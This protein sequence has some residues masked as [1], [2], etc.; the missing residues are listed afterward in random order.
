MQDNNKN[1]KIKSFENGREP[2]FLKEPEKDIRILEEK[3]LNTKR[4]HF[5]LIVVI[6]IAGFIGG[7]IGGG[8]LAPRLSNISF[9]AKLGFIQIKNGKTIVNEQKSVIITE[10]SAIIEAVRKVKPAV[11]SI[12]TTKS[13]RDIFGQRYESKG[14][15]GTGFLITNDGLILTNRHVVNDENAQ[16]DVITYDNNSHKAEIVALDPS[17][18]IAFLRIKGDNFPIVTLGSSSNLEVGQR[19]VAIGNALG[20]YQNTVTTGVVSG[21]GRALT[22]PGSFFEPSERLENVIQTDASINPGNSGGPLVNMAGEVIGIN[23]A[24]DMRGQLVSFSIPI[25]PVKNIIESVMK[26]GKILRPYIGIRYIIIT[27]DIA[28]LNNLSVSYGALIFRGQN[29][30]EL[31]VAP[32]S[33][34]AKAGL[35]END[36]VLEINSQKITEENSLA[37]IILNYKVGDEI[38]LKV[39]R[40]NQEMEIKLVLEETPKR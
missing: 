27:E 2:V 35:K 34:G 37:S 20:E 33:P 40:N 6:L 32:G 11:V 13:F 8:I 36:I 38:T 26:E 15:I 3:P 12:T 10:E 1:I 31:A 19:V 23:T 16:Y 14:G 24:V 18:D 22:I 28:K 25:D 30:T 9:F 5:V 17:L 21:I 4:F 29:I 39:L 7:I